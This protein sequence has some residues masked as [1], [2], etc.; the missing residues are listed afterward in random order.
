MD[1]DSDLSKV[2]K[3]YVS[4]VEDA[5][6]F[7]GQSLNRLHD[8][9]KI[10]DSLAKVCPTMNPVFGVPNMDKVYGGMFSAD[11]CWYRCKLH[12]VVDDEQCSVIYI[13]YGNSEVLNRSNIV[14]L[15]DDLQMA[16][17]AQKFR[18]WGLQL[19]T[20]SDVEQG[21]QFLSKMIGDKQISVQQ[22]TVYKDG[23]AV[24]QV[25]LDGLDVGEEV[26]KKGFAEKCKLPISPNGQ[27][28]MKDA[29]ANDGKGRFS[30]PRRLL[31]RPPMREPKSSPLNLNTSVFNRVGHE[32]TLSDLKENSGMNRFQT[33]RSF[34]EINDVKSNQSCV[35]DNKQLKEEILQLKDEIKRLKDGNKQMKDEK[36]MVL[37]KSRSLEMQL[38][39]SQLDMKKEKEL[40]EQTISKLEQSLNSATGS[41]LKALKNKIDILRTVRLEN[42]Y[43]NIADD[44]M[45]AVKVVNEEQLSAP[46]TLNTLNENWRE[47]D[48]AQEMIRTC[49]DV[50]ELD[51]LIEK[52]NKLQ[53]TLHSSVNDFIVEVEQLPLD[54]RL[55]KLKILLYSLE[56]VYGANSDCEDSETVFQEFSAWK[57]D[58][59]LLFNTVQNET[60]TSL[61]VLS[62]WF[63]DIKE[64]F[65]L[66]SSVSSDCV[67]DV[68]SVDSMMQKVD[69]D[70]SKEL[71]VSL[72]EPSEKEQKIIMNAYN[73]VV[74]LIHEESSLIETVK[75]KYLLSLEFQK[76]FAEWMN[77]NPNVDDLMAVKKTIKGLKAQLK[78]KLLESSSME[79]ADEYNEAAHRELKREIVSLRNK[80]FSEIQ[81]EQE[82]YALLSDLVQ[83]CFPE[84]PLM[85]SDVGIL[86][87]MN[88]GGLLSSSMERTLFD[89][90]PMKE[91][92]SKR[93]LLCTQVQDR[94]VLLKGY[95]VG[96]DTEE[97]VIVRA[98]K[99]HKAAMQQ[100]EES[101][102]MDLL[103]LFF[104][105]S[106]PMVYLMVPFYP[107]ES[108]SA[109]Q[110]TSP[111][112]AYEIVKVMY[113][114]A[115]GMETL[116]AANIII[117]SLH[118]KNVFAANRE[119]GIIGD[120]DFTKDA[121]Q[122]SSST[123]ICFP[124][125][126]AP[127]LKRGEP[128]S[129][130]TDVYSY[131]M[132]LLWLC[133][134]HKDIPLKPNGTPDL[135]KVNLVGNSKDLLSSL[136]CCDNR[137]QTE[138]IKDH[139][140]FM[141]V[142]ADNTPLPEHDDLDDES[143]PAECA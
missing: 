48:S 142:I 10:T 124:L 20:S 129:A 7:W 136:L 15:P 101:G 104:C 73:R 113:G 1:V 91:L 8:I 107:G 75:S 132:I 70:T 55:T 125:F 71:E 66:S 133:V 112:N 23:T 126:T 114:V 84:L 82:E 53:E 35:D 50:V 19:Q 27:K 80:I 108:L 51:H 14:E 24:V 100:R 111:L 140:H 86:N 93:P 46:A 99:Y 72:T 92:S 40:S 130:A 122:R 2:E 9:S 49:S 11:K 123:S 98:A 74:K 29:S 143:I 131:G 56:T 58:K 34:S 22:K 54:E 76:S 68:E 63:T 128:T 137:M 121:D 4:H 95:S 26:V 25:L 36:E 141:I 85:F 115:Q 106:D 52:R 94:K 33:K 78:W 139:K 43:T 105:Q 109:I 135:E 64:V 67:V 134:G 6:T 57:Q 138:Q 21:L 12:H 5:V 119:R 30:W 47:Y 18:M 60:N 110:T 42:G 81:H 3:V 45:E 38:Q 37:H 103:Y 41:R 127:E 39:K 102:L 65:D 117:G 87:Y 17:V 69:S 28:E 16:A 62:R 77:K 116:H 90:E 61:A 120:F 31:E 79:E 32:Q 88:S 118:E 89:T 96:M 44:L 59:L 83:N 13:D 97:Q